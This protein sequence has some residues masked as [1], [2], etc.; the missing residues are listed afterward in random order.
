MLIF[1]WRSMITNSLVLKPYHPEQAVGAGRN[2]ESPNSCGTGTPAG[3]CFLKKDTFA[4]ARVPVP[5]RSLHS[6]FNSTAS[7]M[8]GQTRSALGSGSQARLANF[9]LDILY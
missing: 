3:V 9:S 7:R 6:R 5:H 4:Q 1:R 8:C 2:V